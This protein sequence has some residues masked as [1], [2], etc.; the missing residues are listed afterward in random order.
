M[1]VCVFFFKQ[2]TAYEIEYGLVGSEMCRR[3]SGDSVLLG[4]TDAK[5]SILKL[6]GELIAKIGGHT[7]SINAVSFSP[8]GKRILSGSDDFTA[9]LQDVNGSNKTVFRHQGVVTSVVFSK[10][11]KSIVTGSTDKTAVI[12][13]LKSGSIQTLANV[14]YL[15]MRLPTTE[16]E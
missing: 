4:S 2:K 12:R 15:Q 5:L 9:I 1:V 10:D 8:D 11:G 3:D 13:N 6:T 7:K 14:S 16:T